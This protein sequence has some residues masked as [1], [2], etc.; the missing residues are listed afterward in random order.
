MPYFAASSKGGFLGRRA[1]NKSFLTRQVITRGYLA[2]GYAGGTPW[3]NINYITHSNDTTTNL[4]D[5]IS[6][7]GGYVG[8][9]HNGNRHFVWATGS[10]TGSFNNASSYNM[11][12]HV[13]T[14]DF[15]MPAT[16]DDCEGMQ[17]ADPVTGIGRYAYVHGG[18][19]T[20]K[21]NLSTEA[22][23]GQ[24]GWNLGGQAG[25]HYSEFNG[26]AWTGSSGTKFVFA[27]ETASGASASPSAHDQQKGVYSKLGY[28][29]AGN[30]GSYNGGYN[31]RRWNY[32]TDSMTG[33][34]SKPV[35]NS[36]EENF[37]CGQDH[38]YMLGMYDG[39]Q[40]NRS[41]RFNYASES[42]FEMSGSGL[43]TG[44]SGR[45]SGSMAWRD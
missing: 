42:G 19:S 17:D 12:T 22:F 3:R 31:L 29:W 39:A 4:G 13:N 25:S 18:T 40:N 28:G 23:A 34:V 11:R 26:I 8:S 44:V 9:S 2:A 45:S 41:W 16:Y 35:G 43:P 10:T 32:T 21:F 38:Q 5:L 37:D 15:T 27:T 6:S 33:T 14:G 7:A 30:E 1:N 24:I 36:G 20:S